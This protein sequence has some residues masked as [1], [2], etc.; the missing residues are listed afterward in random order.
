MSRVNPPFCCLPP[1]PSFH[2]KITGRRIWNRTD[3][4][5]CTASPIARIDVTSAIGA[6]DLMRTDHRRRT[7]WLQEQ[8]GSISKGWSDQQPLTE[9]CLPFW[10]GQYTSFLGRLVTS[11]WAEWYISF[12]AECYIHPCRGIVR[13]SSQS[14]MG[15]QGSMR[16]PH[17]TGNAVFRFQLAVEVSFARSITDV[18]LK[19]PP[20]VF[21]GERQI[22]RFYQRVDSYRRVFSPRALIVPDVA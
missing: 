5:S 16:G 21:Y 3:S 19:P 4:L 11:F 6:R 14:L 12:W 17:P 20:N 13:T 2:R 22:F 9:W 10:P 1:C 15:R 8:I 7:H 18:N